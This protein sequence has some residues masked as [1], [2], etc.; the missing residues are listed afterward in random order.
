MPHMPHS[1]A[2][3]KSSIKVGFTEWKEKQFC[4]TAAV[5]IVRAN[6]IPQSQ[7]CGG[8][9]SQFLV[10]VVVNYMDLLNWD[11]FFVG[12]ACARLCDPER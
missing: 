10:Y 1:S 7:F 6:N 8:N 9:D 4:W 3:Q 11:M 5:F 12:R 2:L